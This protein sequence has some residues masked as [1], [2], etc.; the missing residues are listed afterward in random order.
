M[1][2]H[3]NETFEIIWRFKSVDGEDYVALREKTTETYQLYLEVDVE[4]SSYTNHVVR[5]SHS[6][7]NGTF[8][9]MSSPC[10]VTVSNNLVHCATGAAALVP[11]G[12][13]IFQPKDIV[14]HYAVYGKLM[15]QFSWLSWVK[16]SPT[17]TQ[18]M[19][20]FLGSKNPE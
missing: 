3:T 11:H 8:N 15:G 20:N 17:W 5:K 13:D 18:V 1:S 16:D 6:V 10:F 2:D 4:E 9:E 14:E 7:L 12:L 19:A